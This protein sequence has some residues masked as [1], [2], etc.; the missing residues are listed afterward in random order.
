MVEEDNILIGFQHPSG[1]NNERIN[2]LIGKKAK[3]YCS[4]KTNT[5]MIDKDRIKLQ[6][7]IQKLM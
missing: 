6:L 2:Y 7:K 5:D 4:V 1:A 3:K